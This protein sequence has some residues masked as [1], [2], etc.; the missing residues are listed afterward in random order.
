MSEGRIVID[1]S[2]GFGDLGINQIFTMYHKDYPEGRVFN[3]QKDGFTEDSPT[4]KQQGWVDNPAKIGVNVW[5]DP[6]VDAKVK[7][8]K[9][10]FDNGLID[11]VDAP[12]GQTSAEVEMLRT[13]LAKKESIIQGM[14]SEPGQAQETKETMER[15]HD[16]RAD[17]YRGSHQRAEVVSGPD[18]VT[19]KP[20]PEDVQPVVD[21]FEKDMPPVDADGQPTES[22][23]DGTYI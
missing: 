13:E 17:A 5:K 4:L 8:L 10:Q 1:P 6:E 2:K 12:G 19:S 20:D 3:V 23:D 9:R 18:G 14:R 7:D 21:P 22:G 15:I 11:N 16:E